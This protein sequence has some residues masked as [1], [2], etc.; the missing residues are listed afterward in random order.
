MSR[1]KQQVLYTYLPMNTID[2]QGGSI[3]RIR[4]IRGTLPDKH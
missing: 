2:F 1:G 4:N 3:A